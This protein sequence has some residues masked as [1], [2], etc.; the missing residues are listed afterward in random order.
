VVTGCLPTGDPRTH[1]ASPGRHVVEPA[2]AQPPPMTTRSKPT[3]AGRAVKLPDSPPRSA[4]PSGRTQRK[5]QGADT[6]RPHRTLD[7]QTLAPDTGHRSLGQAAVDTGR[8]HRTPTRT[9][10][11]QRSRRPD[12]LGLLAERPH[13]GRPTV[14]LLSHYQAAAGSLCGLGRAPAHCSPR[15]DF[16]SSVERRGACHP[17]YGDEW[18][19]S[20]LGANR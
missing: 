16:G 18:E 4:P 1:P 20:V 13:A 8:S 10:Q 2:T 11:Q 3:S 14:F 12:L 15:N 9:G 19:G 7:A 17:V 6:G 5:P